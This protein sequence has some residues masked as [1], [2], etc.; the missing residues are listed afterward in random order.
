VNFT[1]WV[2]V[3]AAITIVAIGVGIYLITRHRQK[4]MRRPR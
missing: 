2:I 4:Q 3:A 1:D